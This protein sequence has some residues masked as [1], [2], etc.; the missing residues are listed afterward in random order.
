M[1]T[2]RDK[3]LKKKEEEDYIST[4]KKDTFS[5]SLYQPA[6]SIVYLTKTSHQRKEK[7]KII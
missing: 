2:E 7:K 6:N 1:K 4:F 5:K 3:I